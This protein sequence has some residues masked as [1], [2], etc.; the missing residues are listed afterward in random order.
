MIPVLVVGAGLAGLTVA[1]ALQAPILEKS[2]GVG[3]RLAT[4]RIDEQKFDHGLPYWPCHPRAQKL[5]SCKANPNGLT[6]IAKQLAQGLTIHLETRAMRLTR[7]P[8]GWLIDTDK[9]TQLQA[10]KIVL[11]A[12]VPQALELVTASGLPVDD[13]WQVPYTKALVGLYRLSLG[14][15]D[16]SLEWEGHE[17]ILQR[18]K[19][20]CSDGAVFILSPEKSEEWF[21]L[22]DEEILIRMLGVLTKKLGQR[23]IRHQELKKWRYSMSFAVS[24]R[25]YLEAAPGL[26]LCGDGFL[27]TGV[28]GALASAERLLREKFS[29]L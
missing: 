1:R 18:E 24:T 16:K 17:L 28:E 12:P 27:F 8:Q 5:Q 29:V 13:S 21:A 23:K 6:A 19:E 2:R 9:G 20:M 26:F 10:E 3:G 22:T 4:R 25:P 11:T 15:Q 14:P 7:T